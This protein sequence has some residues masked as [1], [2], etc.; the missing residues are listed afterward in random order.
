MERDNAGMTRAEWLEALGCH[1]EEIPGCARNPRRVIGFMEVHIEQGPVLEARDLPVGIVT[2]INGCSRGEIVV[3]GFAGHSGTLPMNMRHDALT[4]ASEMV[5]AVEA[6]AGAEAGLVATVGTLSVMGGAVNVVPGEV[7]ASLD[8]RAASDG[9]RLRAVEDIARL[10]GEIAEKRGVSVE[11]SMRYDAAAAPCDTQFRQ[12]LA[13]AV[14]AEGVE[15]FE[16][17]SGAG[18]DAMAFR[19]LWPIAM[20]FVRCRG[21]VSHNPAEYASPEDMAL[22]ARVLVRFIESISD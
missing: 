19:G 20:L 9:M 2:A 16:L 17:G 15:P 8:V 18:H 14:S 12:M 11:T 3:K 1:P 4:A 13:K 22:A 10:V 5:L 7:R 21:G 6:R